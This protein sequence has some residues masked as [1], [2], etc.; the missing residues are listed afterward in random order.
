SA[1]R[2]ETPPPPAPRDTAPGMSKQNVESA[3]AL[4]AAS[5]PLVELGGLLAPD[6]EFDFT[7]IYPD[8]P[9][10]R[11]TGEMRRFRDEGPWG[12]SIRFEPQRYFDV[13][14]DRVLVFVRAR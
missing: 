4:F 12:R 7:A 8:R 9:V 1:R 11:G 6:I 10:L 14:E 2:P 3:R 13:D 5:N